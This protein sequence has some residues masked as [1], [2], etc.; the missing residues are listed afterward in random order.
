M[1]TALR[2]LELPQGYKGAKCLDAHPCNGSPGKPATV[3]GNL[4][5]TIFP[6]ICK[7]RAGRPWEK[8]RV[9]LADVYL[10]ISMY[11]GGYPAEVRHT[12]LCI[13]VSLKASGQP[14]GNGHQA[15]WR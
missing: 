12:L 11:S 3:V 2:E 10:I 14:R 6:S 9:R 1:P 13:F 7:H 5:F 4:Q 15:I 8:W